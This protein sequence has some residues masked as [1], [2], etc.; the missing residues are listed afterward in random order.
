MLTISDDSLWG[1]EKHFM[2]NEL[3]YAAGYGFSIF[4]VYVASFHNIT[5]QCLMEAKA[6][7]SSRCPKAP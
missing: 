5:L 2:F 1:W 6:E 3:T 7:G 4:H